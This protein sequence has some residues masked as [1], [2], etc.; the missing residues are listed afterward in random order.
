MN[1]PLRRLPN[2]K[3][4]FVGGG[5]A[6]LAG[7]AYL[8]RDAGFPADHIYLLEELP[9]AGGS[10][11][12]SG[13]PATGY[14]IRGGRMLNFSYVCTY[15]LL[16]S[17]PSIAGPGQSV[18]DEIVAFNRAHKSHALSR[19]REAGRALDVTSMGFDLADRLALVEVMTRA[20]KHWGDRRIDQH[21][22]PHFFTTPFW[23]MWATMFAFQPWHSL[24]ELKRYLH[25][26]LHEFPRI[27]TLEGVDR[28]PYNQYDSLVR[29]LQEWL[30]TQGV[31]F[32]L[33]CTV[34]DVDFR[35]TDDTKTAERI[36][37]LY[38]GQAHQLT[39]AD[40]DLAFVTL[41][42]MT[43]GSRLGSM[44]TAPAL[45]DRSDGGAWKLWQRIAA[46]HPDFGRPS[47]F[48]SRVGESKW[49]SFTVTFRDPTFFRRM[50]E[51]TGNPA[52]T[53]GLVTFKDSG[54]L[55][56]IVLAHQPH[57][58]GQPDDVNVCW[59]YGLFPDRPGDY[60]K[61]PMADCTGAEILTD[62]CR[63]LRF[64]AELPRILESAICIPCMMPFITSQF[65]TRSAGD[66]PAVVP[67]GATNFAFLGQF[68]EIPDDVVFTVEYS[69]RSAQIAVY[70][71]LGVERAVIP[72]YKG[73]RDARVLFDAAKTLIR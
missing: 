43:E 46:Q 33:G 18:Y 8:I 9:L 61:K 42:S 34:V 57:F 17:V 50:E 12:G 54:W 6:S 47:R 66:R 44:T 13:S 25:R 21:F 30:A 40:G 63:H 29:P 4:Y 72:M 65:L 32:E 31:H 19:L 67:R 35:L 58:V 27:A 68:V 39:L 69:V 10:L 56:S 38:R 15:D 62:L 55:M 70:S 3:A 16:A 73:E 28:T 41:G 64:D 22:G 51:L 53:G 59:G 45:A 49:E 24:V 37:Y 11:D 5:I 14:V 48:D 7:A 20:E 2:S 71:L 36:H 1:A 52:G 60:V 26:F 23:L